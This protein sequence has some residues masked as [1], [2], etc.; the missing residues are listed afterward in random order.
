MKTRCIAAIV[1]V[2]IL[3]LVLPGLASGQSAPSAPSGTPCPQKPAQ[4]K[5]A[6]PDRQQADKQRETAERHK[7]DQDRSD[8]HKGTQDRTDRHK[9]T[10]DRSGQHK[11][12]DQPASPESSSGQKQDKTGQQ[13]STGQDQQKP[14]RS[15][16]C[17]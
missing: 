2:T 5:D 11:S 7:G 13:K 17:K 10:A 9:G 4:S 1:T 8:K 12:A 16:D 6:A 3:A 14:Q 15:Q